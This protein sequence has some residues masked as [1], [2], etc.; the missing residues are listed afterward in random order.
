MA[1]RTAGRNRSEKKLRHCHVT[2]PQVVWHVQ[3]LVNAY[4]M[5]SVQFVLVHLP[6]A[7][8]SYTQYD[9]YQT[10][11]LWHQATAAHDDIELSRAET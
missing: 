1:A 3:Q 6:T 7:I 2:P 4:T 10:S 9:I 11:F 8:V 5:I